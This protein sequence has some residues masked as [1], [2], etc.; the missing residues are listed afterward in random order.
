LITRRQKGTHLEG[1]WEFPGGKLEPGETPEACLGRELA[2]EVDIE[3][4]VGELVEE[5][6]HVYPEKTVRLLFFRCDWVAREPR[7]VGCAEVA[8]VGADGLDRY[9]FPAAD[10][11]LLGRLRSTPELWDPRQQR[12]G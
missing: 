9:E 8:W 3:V 6:V 1:L 5:V 7:P 11:R 4:A 2:E 12:L 10:A